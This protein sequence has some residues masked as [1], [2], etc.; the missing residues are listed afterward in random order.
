MYDSLEIIDA[1]VEFPNRNQSNKPLD[2]KCKH[3]EKLDGF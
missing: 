1:T 2:R 3:K